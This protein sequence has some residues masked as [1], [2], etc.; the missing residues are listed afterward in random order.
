MKGAV[1]MI[2]VVKFEAERALSRLLKYSRPKMPVIGINV[3]FEI[4]F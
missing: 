1:G 2:G 4:G 3:I